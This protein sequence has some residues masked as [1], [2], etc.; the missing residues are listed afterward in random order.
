MNFFFLEI[1]SV[2]MIN[3]KLVTIS[4]LYAEIYSMLV[5]YHIWAERGWSL[6]ARPH[7]TLLLQHV[8]RGRFAHNWVPPPS[9]A[10]SPPSGTGRNAI[11]RERLKKVI[12]ID[13]TKVRSI[14]INFSIA[15]VIAFDFYKSNFA[16]NFSIK[17]CWKNFNQ[18]LPAKS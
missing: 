17:V 15:I 18:G 4:F 7:Q 2:H 13:S 6:G 14:R 9:C 1:I 8:R 12:A 5:T 3:L 10:T 16:W 11:E